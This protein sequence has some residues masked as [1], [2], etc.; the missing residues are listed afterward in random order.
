MTNNS[1]QVAD[2]YR[3]IAE[4][5]RRL[6]P[7]YT[8]EIVNEETARLMELAAEYDRDADEAAVTS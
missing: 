5:I 2:R 7:A 1:R 6:D 3:Q 4:T 8:D